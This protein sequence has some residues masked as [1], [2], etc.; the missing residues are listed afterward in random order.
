[1]S[2]STQTIMSSKTLSNNSIDTL[3]IEGVTQPQVAQYF[4]YLNAAKYQETAALFAEN[5]ILEAPFEESIVGREAIAT[6]LEAEAKGMQLEPKRGESQVI[7]NGKIQ[8]QVLGKVN[9]P[10]FK[11]NVGWQ[12]I[13]NPNGEI[14]VVTVKLLASLKELLK[15]RNPS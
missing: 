12:F 10:L 11:V 2:V 8:I 14:T 15:I 4:Q 5:G 7:E 9:T 13:L 3:S 6:Y 1:M